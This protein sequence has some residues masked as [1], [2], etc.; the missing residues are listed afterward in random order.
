[1]EQMY[2]QLDHHED[3]Y[4]VGAYILVCLYNA[5]RT[6]MGDHIVVQVIV[7]TSTSDGGSTP[8]IRT[9]GLLNLHLN[10]EYKL[11]IVHPS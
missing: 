3:Q 6:N 5:E 10:G 1:M 9:L 2:T 4:I 8:A 7:S 11:T